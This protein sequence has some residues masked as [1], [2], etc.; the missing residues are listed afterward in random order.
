M[1]GHHK[2]YN[3]WVTKLLQEASP[4]GLAPDKALERVKKVLETL[5]TLVKE[6]PELLSHGPGISPKFKDLKIPFD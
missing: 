2:E 5:K 4:A 6:N 1:K 3:A